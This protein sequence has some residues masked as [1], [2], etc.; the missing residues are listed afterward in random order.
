MFFFIFYHKS[1]GRVFIFNSQATMVISPLGDH[2]DKNVQK[3]LIELK[4]RAAD[5]FSAIFAHILGKLTLL[6]QNPNSIFTKKKYFEI[7]FQVFKILLFFLKRC[8]I[9][10]LRRGVN[11]VKPNLSCSKIAV[12]CEKHDIR[13]SLS[14]WSPGS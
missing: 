8:K 14:K 4:Q 5:M 6:N 7:F 3:T 12:N 10:K 1:V 9:Q 13:T 11:D 2:L